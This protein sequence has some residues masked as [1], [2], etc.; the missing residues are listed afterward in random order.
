MLNAYSKRF[1]FWRNKTIIYHN[2]RVLRR[3][4]RGIRGPQI[5]MNSRA[6]RASIPL[7]PRVSKSRRPSVQQ[8]A[9]HTGK[10]W[11]V[12]NR[13]AIFSRRRDGGPEGFKQYSRFTRVSSVSTNWSVS[14]S[15]GILHPPSAPPKWFV[16]AKSKSL[17]ISNFIV[18][19]E[20][21]N[22]LV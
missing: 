5:H 16:S 7:A 20:I 14:G 8:V 11:N 3:A 4:R 18:E 21:E 15:R 9:E 17:A 6:G 13:P 1:L 12:V 19:G 10:Y 2:C 22:G